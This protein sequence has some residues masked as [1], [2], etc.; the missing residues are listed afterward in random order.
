MNSVMTLV[1]VVLFPVACLLALMGLSWLEDSLVR[2]IEA[3]A[4]RAQQAAKQA[5][6]EMPAR[7]TGPATG[8]AVTPV[9]A[10][11]NRLQPSRAAS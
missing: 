2:G 3:D 6:V 7:R 1:L 11:R 5:V 9:P 4:K 8:P 10:R